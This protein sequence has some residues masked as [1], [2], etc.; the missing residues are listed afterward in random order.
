[1]SRPGHVD[2]DPWSRYRCPCG[3]LSVQHGLLRDSLPASRP[4]CWWCDCGRGYQEASLAAK[5]K[6]P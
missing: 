3:H 4:N 1:M 5:E 2:Y 6:T